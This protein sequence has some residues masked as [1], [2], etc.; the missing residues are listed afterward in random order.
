MINLT[1]KD[2]VA[3]KKQNLDLLSINITIDEVY[4]G[5]YQTESNVSDELENESYEYEEEPENCRA[6]GDFNPKN[7][8]FEGSYIDRYTSI[9]KTKIFI[10]KLEE[11]LD[12]ENKEDQEYEFMEFI[13][14]SSEYYDCGDSF[15]DNC[16]FIQEH[17]ENKVQDYAGNVIFYDDYYQ[18]DEIEFKITIKFKDG[19][20][21]T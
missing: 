3:L 5:S 13:E 2:L 6:F 20:T 18:L 16:D 1:Q 14:L 9:L 15:V 12:G 8:V 4:S 7:K 10:E 21:L 19:E 11:F 17:I